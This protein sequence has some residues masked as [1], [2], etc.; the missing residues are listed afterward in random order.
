MKPL[1]MGACTN[2]PETREEIALHGEFYLHTK[3][4]ATISYSHLRCRVGMNLGC[5]GGKVL[6]GI[7]RFLAWPLVKRLSEF[8]D[9]QIKYCIPLTLLID[10]LELL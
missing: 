4:Q 8:F 7:V 9:H 1:Q 2:M 5:I 10:L 3:K 6:P